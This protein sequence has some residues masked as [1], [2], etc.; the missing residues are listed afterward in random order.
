[1]NLLTPRDLAFLTTS[2]L[3]FVGPG[4]G[5][6]LGDRPSNR[7][8]SGYDFQGHRAYVPGDD[9]RRLDRNVFQRLGR[10]VVREYAEERGPVVSVLV[11]GS[12]S[13]NDERFL[14]ARCLAAALGYVA[15]HEDGDVWIAVLDDERCEG[16]GWFR[17]RSRTEALFDWL[18]DR[19]AGGMSERF[20]E[21]LEEASRHLERPGL[22]CIISDWMAEGV[23][24]GI[25]TIA[26]RSQDVVGIQVLLDS[27]LDP[28][29][30]GLGEGLL[31]LVDA[32]TN[33]VT[34]LSWS[35][36]TAAAYKAELARWKQELEKSLDRVW[37]R[38]FSFRASDDLETVFRKLSGEGGGPR[39]LTRRG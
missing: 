20:G 27:E 32:E 9:L 28:N 12:A 7:P 37:G 34:T 33:T 15:L 24:S 22:T 2:R 21:A 3:E 25:Q 1:M 30:A 23:D 4:A 19:S 26:S 11:D 8:G 31:E 36:E 6:Q 10:L 14:W 13:M 39:L 16:S 35:E 38:F 29:V 18:M 17:G 5:R